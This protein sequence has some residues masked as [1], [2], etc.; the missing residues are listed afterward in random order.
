MLS[1]GPWK[2]GKLE[3]DGAKENTDELK[4]SIREAR[5]RFRGNS[6]KAGKMKEFGEKKS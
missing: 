3:S 5:N 6:S 2:I 4:D 1:S